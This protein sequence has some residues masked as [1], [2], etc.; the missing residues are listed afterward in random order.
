MDHGGPGRGGQEK[1]T[2]HC[3]ENELSEKCCKAGL[4]QICVYK[5]QTLLLNFGSKWQIIT[6]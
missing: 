6:R 5:K 2:L 4:K 3:D 1:D